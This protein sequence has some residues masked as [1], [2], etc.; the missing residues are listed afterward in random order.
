MWYT[1]SSA[2]D[3]VVGDERAVAAPGQ[4]FR[5]HDDC[6]ARLS[7]LLEP[8]DPGPERFGLHVIGVPAKAGI[9]PTGVSGIRQWGTASSQRRQRLILDS[10]GRQALLE[11][12]G[13]E[14]RMSSRK[15]ESPHVYEN[16][17]LMGLQEF[18]KC[19]DRV[20]RM[21]DGP[22]GGSGCRRSLHGFQD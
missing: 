12:L 16:L 22:E 6:G 13:V 9:A 1:I 7:E 4:R 19:L 20:G 11:R 8:G 17:D 2:T 18:R 14:M 15:G 10:N 3:Q 5:A 21:A